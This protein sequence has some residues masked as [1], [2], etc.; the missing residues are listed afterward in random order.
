[1][2]VICEVLCKCKKINLVVLMTKYPVTV[3]GFWECCLL[4]LSPNNF[5]MR[6]APPLPPKKRWDLT[7]LLNSNQARTY[8]WN[9]NQE[10]SAGETIIHWW[11]CGTSKYWENKNNKNDMWEA[12][13]SELEKEGIIWV[14]R[15]W[16]LLGDSVWC[17]Q[18]SGLIVVH[19]PHLI[20]I[21]LFSIH[22]VFHVL[23]TKCSWSL[24]WQN[25][26]FP[27]HIYPHKMAHLSPLGPNFVVAH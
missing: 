4:W 19:I 15:W 26:L 17:R 14:F 2:R 10:R 27:C 13:L 20:E 24:L 8:H 12:V 18:C 7:L 22:Q 3:Q 21:C 23:L 1:M 5:H 16:L 25:L 9:C 11:E 6:D